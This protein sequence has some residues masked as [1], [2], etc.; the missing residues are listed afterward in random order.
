M[1]AVQR[2]G[3]VRRAAPET[4]RRD[5][6]RQAASSLP[7]RWIS[8]RTS[9]GQP[10]HPGYGT[11]LVSAKATGTFNQF[12]TDPLAIFGAFTYENLHGVGKLNSNKITDLPSSLVSRLKPNMTVVSVNYKGL[13]FYKSDAKIERIEGNTVYLNRDVQEDPGDFLHTVYFSDPRSSLLNTQRELDMLEASRFGNRSDPT[14]AQFVLQPTE[15]SKGGS[16]ANVKR[17]TL[18]EAESQGITVVMHWTGPKTPVTFD[19]Y[20]GTNYTLDNLPK[21]PD[22]SYTTPKDQDIFVPDSTYQTFHLN[23]WQAFWQFNKN[24]NNG[25]ANPAEVVVTN[26]QY[27][28]SKPVVKSVHPK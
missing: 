2:G 24:G 18:K 12:A 7:P 4:G 13:P 1:V 28:P 11:Y 21:V 10:F 3:Q 5:D 14:N 25:Q 8:S 27:D 15:P 16:G 9:S 6:R 19:V 17:I 26:F 22:I 23:L 20:Y